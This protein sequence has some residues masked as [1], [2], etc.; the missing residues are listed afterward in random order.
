MYID[1]AA[2]F[3]G[4]EGSTASNASGFVIDNWYGLVVCIGRGGAFFFVLG[5][6]LLLF[7][8]FD[9]IMMLFRLDLGWAVF[10]VLVVVF[11]TLHTLA[12]PR[13]T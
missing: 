8:L 2:Y 1:L 3:F 4:D 6:E 9:L 12:P 11:L 13:A 7:V 10:I 5:I